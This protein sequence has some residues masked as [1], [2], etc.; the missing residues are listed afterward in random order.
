MNQLTTIVTIN[1]WHVFIYALYVVLATVAAL[2]LARKWRWSYRRRVSLEEKIDSL[3]EDV[4]M[5]DWSL[6]R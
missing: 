2:Y 1:V 5:L 6:Y 4:R 3:Q